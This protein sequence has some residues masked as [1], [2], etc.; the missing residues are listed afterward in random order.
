[1]DQTRAVY[2]FGQL[3]R[4]M[5]GPGTWGFAGPVALVGYMHRDR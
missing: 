4:Y 3:T 2:S 1:M 5:L